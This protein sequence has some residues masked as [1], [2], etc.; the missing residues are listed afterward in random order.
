[1]GKF[2]I[3]RLPVPNALVG[4]ALLQFSSFNNTQAMTPLGLCSP[5]WES[6]VLWLSQGVSKQS[7]K[8]HCKG[9]RAF[10]NHLLLSSLFIAEETIPKGWKD[11]QQLQAKINTH[12]LFLLAQSLSTNPHL[13]SHRRGNSPI[14]SPGS[15]RKKTNWSH[16]CRYN[17]H[18]S[19]E[20]PRPSNASP[21]FKVK[22]YSRQVA[23][24]CWLVFTYQDWNLLRCWVQA[25]VMP[26]DKEHSWLPRRRVL[27]SQSYSSLAL[28][29][30]PGPVPFP[31][32]LGMGTG[33][34]RL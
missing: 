10:R 5:L 23:W 34:G 4:K 32:G 27:H 30:D 11:L 13:Q 21:T 3:K 31:I 33:V 9:R 26:V 25:V 22:V 12:F 17:D 28:S 15:Q 1:M 2:V 8:S 18:F 14:F 29:P 19:E 24:F 20:A 16:T 6:K 7:Q